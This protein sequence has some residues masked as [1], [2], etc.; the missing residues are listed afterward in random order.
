[1]S[2]CLEKCESTDYDCLR[3]CCFDTLLG[4]NEK[5]CRLLPSETKIIIKIF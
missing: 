1:M 2:D 4:S 3:K 5:K